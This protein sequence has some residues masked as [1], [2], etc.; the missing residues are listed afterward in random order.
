MLYV[1]KS[2]SRM[3]VSSVLIRE[4]G[5]VKMPVYYTSRAFK[6]AEERY[7]KAEKILFALVVTARRLRPYF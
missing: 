7:P 6:G 5:R 2:V 1:Y 3:M 4:E